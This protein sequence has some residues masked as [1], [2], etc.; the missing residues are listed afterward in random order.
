MTSL[1]LLSRQQNRLSIVPRL[2]NIREYRRLFEEYTLLTLSRDVRIHK[3]IACPIPTGFPTVDRHSRMRYCSMYH[4]SN[5]P[6]ETSQDVTLSD[7]SS[8]LPI[9]LPELATIVAMGPED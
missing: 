9:E 4:V 1:L 8:Y 3:H 5:Q 7:G 2:L 6:A